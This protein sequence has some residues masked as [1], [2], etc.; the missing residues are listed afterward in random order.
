MIIPALDEAAHIEKTVRKA[1]CEE[2]EVIVV[3][4]GSRDGTREAALRAGAS[5]LGSPKG[6]SVQQ[7]RGAEAAGGRVLL[8][9]H[10]DTL[11]PEDYV[12]HIF[13]TLLK[14]EAA[15]GAFRF[16]MDLE[17][18][19]ARIVEALVNF[20]SRHLRMPY[21]DQ[22]LFIGKSLFQ[23]LGGFPMVPIA[24]DYFFVRRVSRL[25]RTVTA[26]AAAT[27]SARRWQSMGFLRTTLINQI[28]LV[29]LAL[30]IS[31]HT[32]ASIYQ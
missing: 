29:G 20:R 27:T 17:K 18:P 14:R 13:E 2:A 30:R 1:L 23:K 8:F 15:L 7:N 25:G 22:A 5:L 19:E 11:V 4:G 9:L 32:L 24:E 21:G 28:I 10:A 12:Y 31:P 26:K 16:K 6:R 3:D